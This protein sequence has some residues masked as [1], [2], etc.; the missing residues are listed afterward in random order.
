MGVLVQPR[1]SLRPRRRRALRMLEAEVS[2]V[3][4]DRL[5]RFTDS[6]DWTPNTGMPRS[7]PTTFSTYIAASQTEH[8]EGN[9]ARMHD[10][11]EVSSPFA[12]TYEVRERVFM[13]G[14]PQDD[15]SRWWDPM[16]MWQQATQPLVELAADQGSP[17]RVARTPLQALL[18]GV[19]AGLIGRSVAM[20]VGANRVAFTLSSLQAT[21]GPIAAAA[22]QADDVAIAAEN[23]A[24][25][26]HQFESVSVRLGNLHTRVRTKPRLVAAPIDVS[27]VAKAEAV[28]E[29]LATATPAV[30]VEIT[31]AGQVRVRVSSHPHVGWVEVQPQVRNGRLVVRPTGMSRGGRLWRLPGRLMPIHPR[32]HLPDTVRITAVHVRP[33]ALEVGLRVDE[34]SLDF[35][36]VASLVRKYR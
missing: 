23:V 29:A 36:E 18:D 6:G 12:T 11:A 33:G 31:D 24:W 21:A 17:S 1:P 8:I 20:G 32:V 5:H 19:R 30:R 13:T 4:L 9:S 3:R 10:V 27:M 34:W 35:L 16:G 25:G 15:K 26:T 22:G 2:G 14:Q 7:S 28:R